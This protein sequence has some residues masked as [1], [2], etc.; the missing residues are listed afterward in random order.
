MH[1]LKLWLLVFAFTGCAA[2]HVLP[3]T[4]PIWL[5]IGLAFLTN[6]SIRTLWRGCGIVHIVLFA[7]LALLGLAISDNFWLDSPMSTMY[8]E[9]LAMFVMGTLSTVL[10]SVAVLFAD[11]KSRAEPDY[12]F[13]VL[14]M[15]IAAAAFAYVLNVI[16]RH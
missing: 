13:V 9:S 11:P 12:R 5:L 10:T 4:T 1:I 2:L 6:S 15:L 7:N 8:Y 3:Y 16:L 14:Q